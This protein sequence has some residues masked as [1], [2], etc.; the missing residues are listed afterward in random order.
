MVENLRSGKKDQADTVVYRYENDPSAAAASIKEKVDTQLG[1]TLANNEDGMKLLIEFLDEIYT[2]D[3]MADAWDKFCDFSY[4]YKKSE[5][6]MSE[7]IANWDNC[8]H[9]L[10][11]ANCEYSDV[12]LAFKLLQASKL[13]E[14]ETKL[15]LTGVD[16]AS[17]KTNKNLL[18]QVKESLKKFKGRPVVLDDRRAVQVN[19][20][21]VTEIEEVL[22]AKGWKPPAKQRRRSRSLS[23]ARSKSAKKTGSQSPARNSKNPNYKGKKNPLGDDHKPLKCFKCRCDHTENCTCPCV[24]HFADKCDASSDKK[25]TSLVEPKPSVGSGELKKSVLSLFVNSNI[26]PEDPTYIIE[27]D[28]DTDDDLVLI[29]KDSL[30]NLVLITIDKLSFID[31]LRMS[32]HRNRDNM[33]EKFLQLSL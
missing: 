23:P 25:K 14:I 27:E 2:K 21:F 22:L 6:S 20:T 5:Q 31:R 3:D 30:K 17:G 28:S 19:D 32:N 7:F 33:D 9:K 18:K 29:T 24:Y 11:S 16:Y 12:I 8:Y 13:N 26:Y 4:F 1:D 15:V 10:K